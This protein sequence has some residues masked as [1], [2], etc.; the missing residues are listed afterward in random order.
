MGLKSGMSKAEMPQAER[1][2]RRRLVTR[3]PV[4]VRN[5]AG[6]TEVTAHTRDVSTNGVFLYSESRMVVG[7]D[8]ELVLILPP[9]LTAGESVGY[10]AMPACYAWNRVRALTSAW[11]PRYGGWI[12]CRKS[13]SNPLRCTI[14]SAYSPWGIVRYAEFFN[15]E[16]SFISQAKPLDCGA[17]LRFLRKCF[18][19][20]RRWCN[21]SGPRS[22]L[23]KLS[24]SVRWPSHVD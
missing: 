5:Q 24:V 23:A 15:S 12:Y 14:S 19:S 18:P 20:H 7:S 22:A 11:P 2:S 16:V 10:V 21:N 17:D 1:R 13:P 4:G 6:V 8:V 9:E 3:L